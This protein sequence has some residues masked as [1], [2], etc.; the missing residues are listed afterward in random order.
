MKLLSFAVEAAEDEVGVLI[1]GTG[2]LSAPSQSNRRDEANVPR[3]LIIERGRTFDVTVEDLV[4]TA[5]T[6]PAILADSVTLLQVESNRIAMENVASR[7]PAVWVSG[8]EIRI[9]HNWLG[10]QSESR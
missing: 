5:S 2:K 6:V 7:W 4:I 8:N 3:A 9:V 1:D 10:I